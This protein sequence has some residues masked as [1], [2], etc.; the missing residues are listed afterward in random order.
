MNENV[1]IKNYLIK[2]IY[3]PFD[4]NI[5]L[6]IHKYVGYT[7]KT[8]KE[9]QNAISQY[10]NV[11]QWVNVDDNNN[12][13]D[14]CCHISTWNVQNIIDFS[15]LFSNRF[16]FNEDISNWNVKNVKNMRKMFSFAN[17]FNKPLDKWDVGNVEDMSFMFEQCCNFNQNINNWNTTS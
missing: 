13:T 2:D 7:P 14:I 4:E 15:Y 12:V 8:K 1:L 11:V 17:N 9:L 10:I 6:I 5:N 3:K 16:N